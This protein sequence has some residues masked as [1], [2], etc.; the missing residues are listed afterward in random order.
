MKISDAVHVGTTPIGSADTTTNATNNRIAYHLG[1]DISPEALHRSDTD[2]E[3]TPTMSTRVHHRGMNAIATIVQGRTLQP[4][5]N[6][7]RHVG[8]SFASHHTVDLTIVP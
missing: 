8:F 3:A 7:D 1:R 5:A 6:R 2:A 4:C